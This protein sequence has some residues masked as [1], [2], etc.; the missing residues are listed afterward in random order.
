MRVARVALKTQRRFHDF[1]LSGD[2]LNGIRFK[3]VQPCDARHDNLLQ[4]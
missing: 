2:Q 1:Y 3:G 4:L